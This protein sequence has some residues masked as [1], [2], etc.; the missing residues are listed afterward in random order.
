MTIG[1]ALVTGSAQGIGRAVSLRLADDG[2]DVAVNDIPAKQPALDTLVEEIKAKGRK[3]FAVPA[4]VS[5]EDQVRGMVESAVKNLGGLDVMVANAGIC[6]STGS[7]IETSAEEWDRFFR[8]NVNGVFFCYKYA[9]KQMVAQGRGGRIIG[10]SSVMGKSGG[11]MVAPYSA[12]KFAIRGLSQSLAQ[13]L[14]PHRITVNTYA[15][16]IIDTPMSQAGDALL[17]KQLGVESGVPLAQIAAATPAG[18]L[19]KPEDVASLVSYLASKEAHFIT[20]QSISPGGGMHF[21]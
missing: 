10:A 13:E 12:T 5:Q 17:C 11:T 7:V 6:Y 9:G 16:G 4:D 19:G 21:D 18:Y 2:F 8:I 1:V 3:A 20:G 15:P 14:G